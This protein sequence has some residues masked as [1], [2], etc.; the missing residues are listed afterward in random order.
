MHGKALQRGYINWLSKN[1]LYSHPTT[2]WI[3]GYASE[4]DTFSRRMKERVCGVGG[5]SI[6]RIAGLTELMGTMSSIFLS[7]NH[8]HN[9]KV[10]WVG[11]N[12]CSGMRTISGVEEHNQI[13]TGRRSPAAV[14]F[15][16][17]FHLLFSSTKQF[18][19]QQGGVI[20][21]CRFLS[22]LDLL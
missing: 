20:W 3:R 12:C 11:A 18:E 9:G 21:L 2:I 1:L 14:H 8:L 19:K 15:S 22:V 17:P 16:S 10:V 5:V 7:A 6:F 13:S 4:I